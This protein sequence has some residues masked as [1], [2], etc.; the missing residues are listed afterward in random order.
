MVI[1]D[2]DHVYDKD[3]SKKLLDG[4]FRRHAKRVL[5]IW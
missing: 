3:H 4:T 2:N 5:G 1:H